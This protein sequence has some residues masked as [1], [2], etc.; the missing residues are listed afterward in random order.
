[1]KVQGARPAAVAG[2]MTAAAVIYALAAV[3]LPMLTTIMGLLWPVFIALVVVRAGVSWG[4]LTAVLSFLLLMPLVTPMAAAA[5][6]L[7]FAPTGLVLGALVR[8]GAG[9]VRTL[10]AGAAGAVG[11]IAA[12]VGVAFALVG[13]NPL[14]LDPETLGR[15][16]EQAADIY[17]AFGMS[18]AQI[19]ETLAAA[20]QMVTLM[21][22][23]LPA[24]LLLWG[25]IEAA[26]SFAVLRMVLARLGTPVA[27][28]PR[29]AAWRLPIVFPYLFGFSLVGIYWGLTRDIAWLYQ[30]ALNAYLAAFFAGL[31]QGLSLMQFL[32][33]R[34]SLSPF[35]RVL[36]YMF[37]GLNAPL[38]TQVVS[39]TGL[40]DMVYNYRKKMSDR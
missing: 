8:R 22:Q 31:V 38:V 35:V 17:R 11:G 40:F 9:T 5:F 28:F 13:I 3:Y 10:I 6:V 25:L 30:I 1:M 27:P 36:L 23:V 19:T 12:G 26:A 4:V 34:F 24:L 37:V 29:F 18:E 33:E 2:V 7:S 21:F 15:T 32:M 39:W 16:M 14:A 20:D